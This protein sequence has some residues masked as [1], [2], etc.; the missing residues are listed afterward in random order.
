M[1]VMEPNDEAMRY[2]Q[3][4]W[5]LDECRASDKH[6]PEGTFVK[7]AVLVAAQ[8]RRDSDEDLDFDVLETRNVD[9]RVL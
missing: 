9:W 5:F 4:T 8:R 6:V 1:G 7:A 3:T 2:P